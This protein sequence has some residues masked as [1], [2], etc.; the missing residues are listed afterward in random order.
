MKNIVINGL[1]YKYL[2]SDEVSEYGESYET[3]FYR[4]DEKITYR[5]YWLFG[6]K[7]TMDSPTEVFNV[8]FDIESNRITKEEL[9]N[10]LEREEALLRREEEIENGILI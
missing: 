6:P 3:V 5:K 4:G 10:I 9:K 1:T 8:G 7:I 2:I